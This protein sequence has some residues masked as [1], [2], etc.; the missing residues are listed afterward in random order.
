MVMDAQGDGARDAT[1]DLQVAADGGDARRVVDAPVDGTGDSACRP[2]LCN[3]RDDD[4]DGVIDNGCPLDQR[5]LTTRTVASTSVVYGSLTEVGYTGFA[6]PCPDGQ[7]VVGLTGNAGSGLDAVGVNCGTVQVREDRSTTPYTYA[8]SVGPGM[9]YAPLGGTGGGQHAIDNVLLCG[10]DEVV[11]AVQTWREP[12]GTCATNG[13]PPGA[14]SAPGCPTVYGM[15][16]SCARLVIRGMPGAFTLAYAGAATTSA[17]AGSTSRT[18]V[19][20]VADTFSCPAAGAIRSL[21]GSYGPWPTSCAITIVNG[22]Q[23]TCTNPVVP[24]R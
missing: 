24:I 18:G 5:A 17:A 4:C 11:A 12:A 22:L 20:V 19:A 10:V 8:V 9:Q 23:L 6:D 2:E 7:V 21:S 13:C 15:G 3:G 14:T 16:V 1:S